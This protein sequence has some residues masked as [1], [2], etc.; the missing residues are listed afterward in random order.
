MP[1]NAFAKTSSD[2]ELQNKKAA[3]QVFGEQLLLKMS[4]PPPNEGAAA[5]KIFLKGALE[6]DAVAV[7]IEQ[8]GLACAIRQGPP[9]QLVVQSVRPGTTAYYKEFSEGDII[10]SI[11]ESHGQ[12]TIAFFRAGKLYQLAMAAPGGAPVS[13]TQVQHFFTSVKNCMVS[14]SEMSK[15]GAVRSNAAMVPKTSRLSKSQK[16]SGVVDQLRV[17]KCDE[18]L[19]EIDRVL[20]KVHLELI[21]YQSCS[22]SK[23]ENDADLSA[24]AW[25]RGEIRDLAQ[26][27]EHFGK[28]FAL[29]VL[30]P[31]PEQSRYM[32]K[33]T[34]EAAQGLLRTV[35]KYSNQDMFASL[36]AKLSELH[37]SKFSI[38]QPTLIVILDGGMPHD[39][40]NRQVLR[41]AVQLLT[42]RADAKQPF[43]VSLIEVGNSSKDV[44]ED[45]EK[46]TSDAL[47][48]GV[49]DRQTYAVAT[50]NGLPQLLVEAV[51]WGSN[52]F[53]QYS[54]EQNTDVSRK[55][56]E[57]ESDSLEEKKRQRQKLENELLAR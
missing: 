51:G 28:S 18:D 1:L 50:R 45:S 57:L 42:H 47:L 10:Q 24:L 40:K 53:R 37:K 52:Q 44:S 36:L 7:R 49:V 14:K 41:Q 20:T 43:I 55:T 22:S 48:D 32:P 23:S 2:Q 13:D 21:V 29:T 15:K 8:V 33:C 6:Q 39:L 30:Y 38:D 46:G 26:R 16:E 4:E 11:T 3:E 56:S 9:G 34:P 35:Q 5:S 12:I 25:C 31:K 27:M 19:D 54:A 17:D